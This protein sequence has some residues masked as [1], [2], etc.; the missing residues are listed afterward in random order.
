MFDRE[1]NP[2]KGL[3]QWKHIHDLETHIIDVR[4]ISYGLLGACRMWK[5][6][7]K[8]GWEKLRMTS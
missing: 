2:E 8:E 1:E 6:I 7:C 4:S 3:R 5:I